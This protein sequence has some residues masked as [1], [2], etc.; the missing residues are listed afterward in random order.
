MSF[1]TSN[2]FTVELDSL[3]FLSCSINKGDSCTFG[4]LKHV[5]SNNLHAQLDLLGV[6]CLISGQPESAAPR[7]P[8]LPPG[9]P[10]DNR[11]RPADKISQADSRFPPL[12]SLILGRAR[13]PETT[14]RLLCLE[15]D[16]SAIS[17]VYLL[18]HVRLRFEKRFKPH[19]EFFSRF[20]MKFM[21]LVW[22]SLPTSHFHG[23]QWWNQE[24][25]YQ[26]GVI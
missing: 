10:P 14:L 26:I 18:F 15:I 4:A 23:F 5:L 17:Y 13:L 19:I 8:A 11:I 25:L 9:A 7:L 2:S 6:R 21:L 20:A 16:P 1:W 22:P 24:K 12:S 3:F